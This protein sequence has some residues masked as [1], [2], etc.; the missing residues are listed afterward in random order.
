ML[1]TKTPEAPFC[2]VLLFSIVGAG[3]VFQHIPNDK[4]GE[5]PSFVT[6]PPDM[7]EVKEISVTAVVVIPGGV[8]LSFLQE[9]NRLNNKINRINPEIFNKY[10]IL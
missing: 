8:G 4:T 7:E 6:S 9:L 2:T 3:D 5:L 1:L 10:F